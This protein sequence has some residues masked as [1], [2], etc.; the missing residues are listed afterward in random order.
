MVYPGFAALITLLACSIA[1]ARR[2]LAIDE[3]VT[4]FD[5]NF[6]Y[7]PAASR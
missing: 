7:F 6:N 5:P 4:N 1:S 2:L 3:C